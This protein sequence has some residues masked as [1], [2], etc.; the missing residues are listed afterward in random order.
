M[1]YDLS[2]VNTLCLEVGEE[3][4]PMK[5]PFCQADHEHKFSVRRTA[6]GY[7]YSCFR[8]KCGESGFVRDN[9]HYVAR[10]TPKE[11]EEHKSYDR[12]GYFT[13]ISQQDFNFFVEQWGVDIRDKRLYITVDGEYA[14]A[15]LGPKG[16]RKGWHIRQPRWKGVKCH[17]LGA[18]GP[19]GMTYMDEKGTSKLAWFVNKEHN[20]TLIL[21]EDL[22]SAMKVAKY[23][24]CGALLGASL[25]QASVQEIRES[26][27]TKVV[28][29]L[30][31]DAKS[32]GLDILTKHGLSLPNVMAIST[33][34]DPK[35]TSDDDI[36]AILEEYGI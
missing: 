11:V 15:I 2:F 23:R 4:R 32:S 18:P 24:T 36:K 30:D 34:E 35:D 26:G 7:L 29:W 28:V 6:Q 5:C 12:A 21:V 16:N 8:A 9:G 20:D 22:V 31:P 17:R 13:S 3:S 19:K 27:V 10:N 1:S 33:D 14:F 25:T